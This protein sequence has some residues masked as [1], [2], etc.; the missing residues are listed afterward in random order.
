MEEAGLMKREK[1]SADRRRFIIAITPKALRLMPAAQS[2][3]R[4]NEDLFFGVLRKD[5]RQVFATLL[6]KLV[7]NAARV[8]SLIE[9]D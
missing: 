9:W 5:E 1:H 2:I 6:A 7:D 8:V 3:A 4:E